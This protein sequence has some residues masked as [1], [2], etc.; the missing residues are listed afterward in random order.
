MN[1]L[2]CDD[3]KTEAHKLDDMMRN[4]GFD[5]NIKVFYNA[6]DVIAYINTGAV[7]DVCF[8][9]IMMP[10]VSGV[11]LAQQLRD[12][13][14]TG[15]I[16]FLS[17]SKDYG[18]ESYK[19]KAFNYL[20]KPISITD[21]RTILQE[22]TDAQTAADTAGILVKTHDLTKNLP[23]RNIS[24]IEVENNYVFFRLT[25]GSELKVRVPLSDIASQLLE[26]KRF[27]RCHRSYIV[28]KNEI[29]TLKNNDFIMRS[30]AVIP[31]SRNN[32]D[33]KRQYLDSIKRQGGG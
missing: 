19:V 32:A 5:V 1:I 33:V 3:I 2:I 21:I 28:N 9:D 12:T 27:I 10:E 24:Y 23:L 17:A 15:F 13:G 18:P 31:I 29:D 7:I 11:E 8:L 16:V 14:Y 22:L 20:V 25:D 6:R 26:D 4:R 30:G